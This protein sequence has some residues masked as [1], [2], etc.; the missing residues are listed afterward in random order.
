[1]GSYQGVASARELYVS[2]SRP[3]R[4]QTGAPR[5]SVAPGGCSAAF[6]NHSAA[7]HVQVITVALGC[8]YICTITGA[9]PVHT[10]AVV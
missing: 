8:A 2:R 3:K 5:L 10:I 1:M 7:L 4:P 6:A 9:L